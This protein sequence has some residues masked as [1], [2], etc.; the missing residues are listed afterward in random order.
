[1]VVV[2]D[3]VFKVSEELHRFVMVEV[4]KSR[5]FYSADHYLRDRLGIE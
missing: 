2:K 1:M 5:E 4:A 3:K